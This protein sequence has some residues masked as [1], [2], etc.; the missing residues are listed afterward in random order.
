[1]DKVGLIAPVIGISIFLLLLLTLMYFVST[2]D[3][4]VLHLAG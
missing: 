2:L 4:T 3:Q 1:M